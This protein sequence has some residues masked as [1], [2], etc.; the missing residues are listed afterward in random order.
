M[1]TGMRIIYDQDGEIVASFWQSSGV[2]L[3]EITKIGHID[4]VDND[5][6]FM[7]HRIVKI[8][9]ETR[10][11]ILE[12]IYSEPTTEEKMKELEDQILI[13]ANENTGGI[14]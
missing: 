7:T 8:D 3:K 13:L 5:I 14:L 10:L 4:F 11:P 1:Q 2:Q 6:N 12:R 9:P